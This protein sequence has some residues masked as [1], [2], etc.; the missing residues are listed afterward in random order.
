MAEARASGVAARV[1]GHDVGR[2]Q[3]GPDLVQAGFE[4][5]TQLHDVPIA[6]AVKR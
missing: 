2:G 3:D 5:V 4:A 6:R 1:T